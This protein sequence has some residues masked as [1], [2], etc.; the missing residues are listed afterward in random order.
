MLAY[1]V[2]RIL[3]AGLTLS[4]MSV[5]TFVVMQLPEGTTSTSWSGPLRGGRGTIRG[6]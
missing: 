2:R 6:R 3:L 4:L 5:L 1:I